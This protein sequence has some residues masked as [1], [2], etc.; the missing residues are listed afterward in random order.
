MKVKE[1]KRGTGTQG[2]ISPTSI[3][4][5]KSGPSAWSSHV[6]L[7]SFIT[8][9]SG[10]GRVRWVPKILEQHGFIQCHFIMKLVRWLGKSTLVY[11]N[12]SLW[13]NWFH[14]MSPCLKSQNLLTTLKRT[15]YT[16]D[17]WTWISK[18]LGAIKGVT[19]RLER[20]ENEVHCKKLR[21]L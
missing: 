21:E 10:L 1:I 4:S 9:K 3:H 8:G 17:F 19:V 12:F 15:Y 5:A 14:Y 16:L 11:I 18:N 20:F 2:P 13:K 7:E 6:V